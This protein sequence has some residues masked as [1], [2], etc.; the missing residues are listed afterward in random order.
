MN[1]FQI[2]T[3]FKFEQI[4]NMN[5]IQLWTNFEFLEI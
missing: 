1:K 5:K 3:K 4:L 2:W